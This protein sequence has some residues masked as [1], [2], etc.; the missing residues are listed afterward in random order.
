MTSIL[1]DVGWTG[2]MA[3]GRLMARQINSEL[4]EA[5]A[6]LVDWRPDRVD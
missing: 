5:G 3:F 4:E 6:F 2:S 1:F